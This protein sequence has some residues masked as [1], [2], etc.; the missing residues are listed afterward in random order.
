MMAEGGTLKDEGGRW[1][2][3]HLH[4][5]SFILHPLFRFVLFAAAVCLAAAAHAAEPPQSVWLVSTRG[6]PQYGALDDSLGSLCYWRLTDD[7][8]WSAAD[9]DAF[10]A[11]DDAAVPTVVYIHGNRTGADDA[12]ADGWHVYQAVRS[13]V[14]DRA[15]RYVIW[16]WPADRVG[17]RNRPD[18]LLKAAYCDAESYYLAAWMARLRPG[19]KVGLIGHSFGPRIITGAMHLLG[20]GQVAGYEMPEK[21]VA[22]WAAGK[23]NPVRA[24]LLAAAEDVDALSPGGVNE[25][26]LSLLDKA[27]ITV[28]RYDRVLRWYPRMCGRGGPQALGFTGPC[29]VE[30]PE[31]TEL[32]DVSCTVGRIHDWRRYCAASNVC[33]R[34]AHYAFLE[35]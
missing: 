19:V 32:V 26:A 17:R 1:K 15:F 8:Q 20:G 2:S 34:W 16:S 14:P 28:N 29:A 33:S 25:R 11:A 31:K 35:E 3:E 5:S 30:N 18:I 24:V 6:A 22:A 23:R 4:P 21:T 9:A 7:C 12:V 13:Q 27:L 10:A